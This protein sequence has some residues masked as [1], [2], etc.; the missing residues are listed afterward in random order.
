MLF[1]TSRACFILFIHKY[2]FHFFFTK[3][4]QLNKSKD[5]HAFSELFCSVTNLSS[6]VPSHG[7]V[8]NLKDSYNLDDQDIQALSLILPSL[9]RIDAKKTKTIEECTKVCIKIFQSLKMHPIFV[10]EDYQ[11]IDGRSKVMAFRIMASL[12]V[13]SLGIF[14]VTEGLMR[15]GG[16]DL[17]VLISTHKKR[18]MKVTKEMTKMMVLMAKVHQE[19]KEVF[20]FIRIGPMSD[21]STRSVIAAVFNAKDH[22]ISD[23]FMKV[24]EGKL[25]A[26]DLDCFIVFNISYLQFL[27]L[28]NSLGTQTKPEGYRNTPLHLPTTSKTTNYSPYK[29]ME[30]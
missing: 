21:Q 25:G 20:S 7:E 14:I 23:A 27:N 3:N 10:C 5:Y 24:I 17:D 6:R 28:C 22:E 26:L 19:D 1:A 12:D 11:W 29:T 2:P 9:K 4:P 30:P 16:V 15:H 18:K 8:L 13:K